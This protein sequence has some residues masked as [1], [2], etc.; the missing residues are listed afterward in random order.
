MELVGRSGQSGVDLA[1]KARAVA[2]IGELVAAMP[3]GPAKATFQI[4][5]LTARVRLGA[6]PAHGAEAERDAATAAAVEELGRLDVRQRMAGLELIAANMPADAALAALTQ[7]VLWQTSTFATFSDRHLAMWAILSLAADVESAQAAVA[8]GRLEETNSADR[9]RLLGRLVLA[10]VPWSV[11]GLESLCG[12]LAHEVEVDALIVAFMARHRVDEP[13]RLL[14]R[15]R[16]VGSKLEA[17]AG[18]MMLG[19]RP[20][21]YGPWLA[22]SDEA[23]KATTGHR[24]VALSRQAMMTHLSGGKAAPLWAKALVEASRESEPAM[25][26]RAHRAMLE[27]A[28]VDFES[29]LEVV[30]SIADSRLYLKHVESW[31]AVRAEVARTVGR[32]AKSEADVDRAQEVLK[33]LGRRLPHRW[34]EMLHLAV[35]ALEY[36]KRGRSTEVVMAQV[37]EWLGRDG[38]PRP[39][40]QVSVEEVV[41]PLVAVAPERVFGWAQRLKSPAQ[42]IVWLAALAAG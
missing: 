15:V 23:V 7:T 24:Q 34:F 2:A 16:S 5:W 1:L 37:E 11:E 13:E 18:Q 36:S 17:I 21:S 10:G 29:W 6:V 38:L 9:I 19:W 28:S 27:A 40:L 22:L 30:R 42:Q 39:I 32:A 26:A 12:A 31:L 33:D 3:P 20:T 4:L 25:A 41:A 8:A 14:S 35:I